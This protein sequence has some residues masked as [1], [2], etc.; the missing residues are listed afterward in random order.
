MLKGVRTYTH[1]ETDRTKHTYVYIYIYTHTY[2]T[3]IRVCVRM[4]DDRYVRK[5]TDQ[6]RQIERQLGY[7]RL[8]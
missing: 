4:R 5:K 3:H 7:V 6:A 8:E 1:R 2:M